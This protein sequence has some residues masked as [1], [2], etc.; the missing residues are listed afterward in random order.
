MCGGVKS[1]R[2]NDAAFLDRPG[3]ALLDDIVELS[4]KRLQRCDLGVDHRRFQYAIGLDL[5]AQRCDRKSRGL[6]RGR[7]RVRHRYRLARHHR[8]RHQASLSI[9]GG[10]QIARQPRSEIRSLQAA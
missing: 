3:M 7:W 4:P 6:R 8:R 5:L 2:I 10:W 1:K 9:S